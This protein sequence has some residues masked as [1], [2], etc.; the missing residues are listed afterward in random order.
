MN[1]TNVE[2]KKLNNNGRLKG[3]ATITIDNGFVIHNV[4]IL[5]KKDNENSYFIAFPNRKNDKTGT[6]EDLCHPINPETRNE[7]TEAVLNEFYKN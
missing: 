5:T 6:F 2:I 7:I 3:V 1:I 4:K